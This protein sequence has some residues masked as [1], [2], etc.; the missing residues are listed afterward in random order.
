[1]GRQTVEDFRETSS[2][3]YHRV[4]GMVRR[5][6]VSLTEQAG[7]AWQT[8]GYKDADGNRETWNNVE[9]FGGVGIHARPADSGRVEAII[10]HVGADEEHPVMVATRDRSMQVA[11]EADETAIFNGQT[12]I[13]IKADGVVEIGSR[14]AVL[15]PLDELVHGRGVDPFTGLTYKVLGSTTS[16]VRAEK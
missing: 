14:G 3:F 6:V 8:L 13:R 7:G 15:T 4:R 16:K 12:I 10:L 11:L 5:V 2:S 9:V 1:M